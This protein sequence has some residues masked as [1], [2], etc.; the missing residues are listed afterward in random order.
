MEYAI[1][2]P[3]NIGTTPIRTVTS[4]EKI[5]TYDGRTVLKA[6]LYSEEELNALGILL[7]EDPG[8]PDTTWQNI[9]GTTVTIVGNR[10][11]VSYTTEMISLEAAKNIRKEQIKIARNTAVYGGVKWVR[12]ENETYITDSDD[13]AQPRL[14]GLVVMGAGT[15]WR[16]KDNTT[17]SLSATEVKSLAVAVGTHVSTQ[18]AIQSNLE[19]ELATKTTVY[20]VIEFD[21]TAG[22]T[23]VPKLGTEE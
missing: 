20:E 19:S 1:V 16:M 13:I 10:A 22:F 8:K 7:V 18:F 23:P 6:Y 2:D 17:V 3:N 14:V 21:P 4:G 5:I 11:V 12:N 15:V 9:T